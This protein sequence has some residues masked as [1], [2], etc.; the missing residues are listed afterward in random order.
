[1]PTHGHLLLGLTRFSAEDTYVYTL[2]YRSM[3]VLIKGMDAS[4][5][6]ESLGFGRQNTEVGLELSHLLDV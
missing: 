1:M 2:I 3:D 4:L 6:E 5:I